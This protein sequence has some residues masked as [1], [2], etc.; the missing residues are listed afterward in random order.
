M[1]YLFDTNVW[2]DLERGANADLLQR[3]AD[4]TRSQVCVS[5]VVLGELLTGAR[6]SSDPARALKSVETLL[7]GWPRLGMDEATVETYAT[8]RDDLRRRGEMIGPNDL[9]IAAQAVQHDLI[10][11]TANVDEFSQIPQ[12]IVENWR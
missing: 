6:Y 2:I 3:A 4:C 12:L 7:L 9:W 11:V 5:V 10:L 8:I 1:K